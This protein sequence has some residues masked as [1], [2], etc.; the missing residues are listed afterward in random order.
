[1]GRYARFFRHYQDDTLNGLSNHESGYLV[2][3]KPLVSK[4]TP[5]KKTQRQRAVSTMMGYRFV[6]RLKE[7]GL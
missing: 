4:F 7:L 6:K 3:R 2:N 1:M 5:P